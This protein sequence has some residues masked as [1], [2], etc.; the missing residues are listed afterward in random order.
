[1][2]ELIKQK[3]YEKKNKKEYNTGSPD[4]NKRKTHNERRTDSKN[5]KIRNK[6]EK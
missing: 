5:G 2:I 1:M 3:T 4:I 6:T